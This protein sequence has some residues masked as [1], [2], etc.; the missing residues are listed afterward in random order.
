[1]RTIFFHSPLIIII[2]LAP[3]VTL[4]L[5][6]GGFESEQVLFPLASTLPLEALFFIL[7]AHLCMS[8]RSHVSFCQTWCLPCVPAIH[9]AKIEE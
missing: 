5:Q 4:L 2:I 7:P 3:V 6:M 1:L 9:H 8:H